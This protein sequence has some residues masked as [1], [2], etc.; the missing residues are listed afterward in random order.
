ME[1]GEQS[2]DSTGGAGGSPDVTTDILPEFPLVWKSL[3]VAVMTLLSSLEI[4]F[5]KLILN[6]CLSFI[7]PLLVFT[8]ASEQRWVW[9]RLLRSLVVFLLGS[10]VLLLLDL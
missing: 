3:K 7:D 5:Q 1:P 6:K 9:G 2:R 8:L 4:L 10:S